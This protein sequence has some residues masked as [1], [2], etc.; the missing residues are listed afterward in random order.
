MD[1]PIVTLLG[2]TK[3]KKE[4]EETNQRLTVRGFVVLSLGVFSQADEL[5]VSEK[6]KDVLVEVHKQKIRM[7]DWVYVID[8]NGYIGES[9]KSEIEYAKSLGKKIRYLSQRIVWAA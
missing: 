8:P 5:I 4:F 9:T 2:S 6:T 1:A 3:F 7:A